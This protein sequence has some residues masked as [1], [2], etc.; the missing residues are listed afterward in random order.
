MQIRPATPED[1]PEMLALIRGLAEYEREPHAVETTEADLLRDGFGPSPFFHAFV[2]IDENQTVGL[3]LYFYN[4]STW[5]GCPG[6]HLEDLFVQPAFRGRGIGKALLAAVA[7]VAVENGCA[8]LQWDVLEWN[9]PAIDFY[10]S[11]GAKFLDQWRT[12]RVTDEALPNLAASSE[13]LP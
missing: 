10:H 1:A 2:A 5:R 9:Q 3:A 4:W 6:I 7:A 12:M 11:V 13:R 8:R